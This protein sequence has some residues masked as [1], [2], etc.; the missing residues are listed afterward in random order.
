MFCNMGFR[1]N[2][3]GNK[4]PPKAKYTREEIVK[5]A[6]QM[7]RENGI[8]SV[9]ARELGKR[10]G[11]SSS[12]IFTAFK[13]MEELQPLTIKPFCFRTPLIHFTDLDL[14][15]SGYAGMKLNTHFKYPKALDR[16]RKDNLFLINF[17]AALLLIGLCNFL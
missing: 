7:T 16:F 13:N 4:M 1:L 15:L 6:F 8:E 10:L 9:M 14:Q 3:R 2:K 5:T 17:L 12:P 11:T